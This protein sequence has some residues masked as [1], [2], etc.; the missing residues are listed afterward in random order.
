MPKS[1]QQIAMENA[2][3]ARMSRDRER[4]MAS[5]IAQ[6]NASSQKLNREIHQGFS[7]RSIELS[8]LQ[9]QRT[10]S[11]SHSTSEDRRAGNLWWLIFLGLVGGSFALV[12]INNKAISIPVAC[13][14][15]LTAVTSILAACDCFRK[16]DE[17]Q[18]V[19]ISEEAKKA[20]SYGTTMNV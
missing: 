5:I 12:A 6:S 19:S 10:G 9:L 16:N 8:K 20:P 14:C 17:P 3:I 1:S 13:V 18:K 7:K 15:Y 11:I 4:V 2:Q